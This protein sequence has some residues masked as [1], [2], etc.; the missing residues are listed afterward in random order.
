MI[1]GLTGGI[2]TGKSE[3]AKYF[4]ALG[5]YVVDADKI[6]RALTV[7]GEPL[8]EEIVKAF[9]EKILK[10]N[11]VL[12]RRA[13]GEIIFNDYS[14]KL[15]LERIMHARIIAAISN[16]VSKKIKKYDIVINAPL[17]FEVA[18]DRIC[19]KIVVVYAPLK[20]QRARLAARD[21]LSPEQ[22]DKRI[23]S[24]MPMDEKIA[25][26]D[27]VIDNSTTKVALKKNVADLYKILK[28]DTI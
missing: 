7:R 12:N 1:I 28:K 3:S 17:L 15:K 23:N 19:D 9:G 20:I 18:L 2:A 24:Q 4:K 8:L 6:A 14:K 11:G 26:A 13:V 22:I 5:A 16:E 25:M 27:Y 10:S 21:R